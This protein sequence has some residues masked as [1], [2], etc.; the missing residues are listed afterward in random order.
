MNCPTAPDFARGSRPGDRAGEL[1]PVVRQVAGE[2]GC[3]DGAGVCLA[4]RAP[5]HSLCDS[6][7]QDRPGEDSG[8][9]SLWRGC[10]H[11]QPTS[12]SWAITLTVCSEAGH[13][14][15]CA[16]A[17]SPI[18]RFPN[19]PEPKRLSEG[20]NNGHRGPGRRWHSLAL[21]DGSCDYPTAFL[22]GKCQGR[23]CHWP[24]QA[25]FPTPHHSG[26]LRTAAGSQGAV[27]GGLCALVFPGPRGDP[28]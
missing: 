10:G 6:E 7:N 4:D 9:P 26:P 5:G 22:E 25:A 18:N 13:Y 24:L 20:S 14:P 28:Q 11:W 8:Q 12:Q 23:S 2:R 15:L 27:P 19:S 17:A 16:S 1:G 3:G 21:S